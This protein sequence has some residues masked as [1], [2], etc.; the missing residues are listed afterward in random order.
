M[1]KNRVTLFLT[2]ATLLVAMLGSLPVS[3]LVLKVATI[4]PDGT[5]WMQK[6]RDG[7]DEIKKQTQGRVEIK[8]YP[9]GVM[10]SDENVL[11]KI[12]IGQ[13]QGGAVTAGSLTNISKDI[14]IYGLPFLFSS[15]EEVDH[16]RSQMD[17]VLKQQLESN[18]FVCFG[19]AEGGFSYMMS[20]K[21]LRTVDDVRDRKV[22]LPAGNDVGEAVFS[23]ANISPVSLPISDVLTAMQTGLI[24][25]IITSPI[26]AIALQ[27]HT[28]I[29]YAVDVPLIYYSALLVIDKKAFSKINTED[30]AIVR[31]IMEVRFR[32]IDRQNRQDNI[33]A[34]KAL[35]NQGIEFI[36]LTDASLKEWHA[37]GELAM[38]KLEKKNSFTPSI[39]DQLIRSL[40]ASAAAN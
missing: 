24:D 15:L 28:R 25:T 5:A 16:V 36:K 12:R 7:A 19:L 23:S 35:Q 11:R 9:G 2:L 38:K 20:N 8:F 21:P 14:N 18:G 33:A 31:S 17:T 32:E 1:K 13:L 29:K 6:M 30:A 4:S 22:W 27:W 34:R 39:Y 37:I 26:G 10:G 40:R 3:A